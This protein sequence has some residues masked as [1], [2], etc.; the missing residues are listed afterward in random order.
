M[1]THLPEAEPPTGTPPPDRRAPLPRPLGFGWKAAFV[2]LLSGILV[3]VGVIAL[4]LLATRGQSDAKAS[5][6][7]LSELAA[8]VAAKCQE[9]PAEARKTFGDV[10]GTAKEID[11]RP[12]GQKGDP[13]KPGAAGDVGPRGPQGEPGE[14]GPRGPSGPAGAAGRTPPCIL[15]I[16]GCDGKTGAT[17]PKGDTGAT[18]AKGETG[19]V[20]PKGDPGETGAT[21]QTGPKGDTGEQGPKG[22]TGS[23]GPSGP[24]GPE[25]PT[26]Y[27]VAERTITSAESPMG[28]KTKV[29]IETVANRSRR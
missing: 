11:D 16:G 1:T 25:C 23:Q 29:C 14:P 8:Q 6:Q 3:L 27:E 28:E 26:G 21:G 12:I 20:G 17:G 4:A 22:E 24:A 2:V 7:T 9:N 19:S 18:G 13:G 5:E 15:Q 10:C